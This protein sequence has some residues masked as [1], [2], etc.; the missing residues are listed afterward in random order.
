MLFS[1]SKDEICLDN[2]YECCD[3]P[4]LT[5]PTTGYLYGYGKYQF[6]APCFN[7]ENE[8]EFCYIFENTEQGL[9]QLC[10]YNLQTG[11]H[12]V[13]LEN[14]SIILQPK[15]N[16]NDWI[17]FTSVDQLIWKVKHN[18]DS[19]IQLNVNGLSQY[20]E[21]SPF[22]ATLTF[23]HKVSSQTLPILYFT[24]LDGNVLDSLNY[25]HYGNS[26]WGV[27]AWSGS[28]QLAFA[29]GAGESY[30]LYTFDLDSKSLSELHIWGY[31]SSDDAVRDLKWNYGSFELFY[32]KYTTGV[33]KMNAFDKNEVK[34]KEGCDSR[35]YEVISI[36][37]GG[38]LLAERV[39]SYID[40]DFENQI[41]QNSKIYLMNIDGSNEYEI[42]LPTN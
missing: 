32:T 38:K 28:N 22:S 8:N 39:D 36:S 1:C 34:I 12:F 2:G 11:E 42:S 21:I 17:F 37:S 29:Y 13:I 25:F 9:Q 15:W 5:G 35:S 31:A 7:P 19:L 14:S 18:G 33:F 3:F 20:L 27:S 30:G 16:S 10:R 41:I 4:A 40:P 24:D 6:K 23:S 26:S